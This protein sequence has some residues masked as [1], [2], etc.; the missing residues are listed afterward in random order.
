MNIKQEFFFTIDQVENL[1][2]RQFRDL[3]NLVSSATNTSLT[4]ITA[5]HNLPA[6][7]IV[8]DITSSVWLPT[9]EVTEEEVASSQSPPRLHQGQEAVDEKEG[10]PA[11]F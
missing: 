6:L 3:N 7:S 4:S 9:N 8:S 2:D 10:L 1:I 5:Q 11:S